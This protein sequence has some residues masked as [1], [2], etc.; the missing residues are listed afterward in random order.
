MVNNI[1][2]NTFNFTL[3]IFL[4]VK[5]TP[6]NTEYYILCCGASPLTPPPCVLSYPGLV[7][8]PCS[9]FSVIVVVGVVVRL[10]GA[11]IRCCGCELGVAGRPHKRQQCSSSKVSSAKVVFG[12]GDQLR[13]VPLCNLV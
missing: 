11:V 8:F 10:N 7:R 3:Y 9:P 2:K 4:F 12:Y 6:E 1:K 13:F 5:L